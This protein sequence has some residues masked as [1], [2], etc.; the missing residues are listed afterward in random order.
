MKKTVSLGIA[1]G[2]ALVAAGGAYA[3]VSSA[4]PDTVQVYS[5]TQPLAANQLVTSSDI[6]VREVTP[7]GELDV[8]ITEEDLNNQLWFAQVG[9]PAGTPLTTT[10]VGTETKTQIDLPENTVIASF[11]AD[12]ASAVAGKVQ[13]GSYINIT[14]VGDDENGDEV[15]RV[16]L[17]RIYVLDVTTDVSSVSSTGSQNV[18]DS[19]Q[20][21]PNNPAIYGGIPSLYTVAVTNEQAAKLALARNADLYITLTKKDAVGELDVSVSESE[22]FSGG[23]VPATTLESVTEEATETTEGTETT[24]EPVVDDEVETSEPVETTEEEVEEEVTPTV[25]R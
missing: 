25:P 2:A 9:L 23:P 10:V 15:A 1:A 14:A 21:G 8:Y 3:V 6:Q 12:P 7:D 18:D 5:L 16:I 22:V 24:D 4:Q 19:E 13:A 11:E 17:N 20:P